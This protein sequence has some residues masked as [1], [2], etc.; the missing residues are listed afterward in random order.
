[1]VSP[2]PYHSFKNL[3]FSRPYR[4]LVLAV[5]AAWVIMLEYRVTLFCIGVV[6]V[7][8]GPIEWL[9]RKRTGREL[10]VQPETTPAPAETGSGGHP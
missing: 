10:A 2:V 4:A 8:S 6:Y 5:I 9:W 3:N 1:M 7:A